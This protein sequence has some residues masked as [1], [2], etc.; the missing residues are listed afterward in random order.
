MKFYEDL[1]HRLNTAHNEH[2]HAKAE[3]EGRIGDRL[4]RQ[5][6]VA[7]SVIEKC[8]GRKVKD[9]ARRDFHSVSGTWAVALREGFTVEALHATHVTVRSV[10]LPGSQARPV[11]YRL[12]LHWLT[13]SDRDLAKKLRNEI[14]G[15]KE[16]DRSVA[17][18]EAKRT[19]QKLSRT[20]QQQER[21]LEKLREEEAAIAKR[22]HREESRKIAAAIP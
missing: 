11:T 12:D 8:N 3:V 18:K 6:Q 17:L 7:I 14:R 9:F 21:K 15:F 19:S 20:I 13:L 10:V 5:Q 1:T 4:R 16:S 22:L 2:A